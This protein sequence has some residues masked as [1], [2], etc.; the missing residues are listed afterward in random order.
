MS[1]HFFTALHQKLLS[2]NPAVNGYWVAQAGVLK[3]QGSLLTTVLP[4]VQ[5]TTNGIED[6]GLISYMLTGCAVKS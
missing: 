1:L 3:Q 5:R 4:S 6:W 2:L